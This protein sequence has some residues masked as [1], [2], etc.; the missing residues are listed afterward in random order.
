MVPLPNAWMRLKR[1][2]DVFIAFRGTN[3]VD[4]TEYARLTNALPRTL[5]VGLASSAVNNA[6]GQATTA[7]YREFSDFS[8]SILTQPLSQTVTSDV[9][10]VF[11]VTARGLPA[12][13]YQWYQNGLIL[14]GQTGA[15]L[16]LN[17]VTTNQAGDYFAVVTNLYGAATSHVATLVVDGVG[18]GGFEGDVAPLPNGNNTVSVSDWVRVGR[19]VA[20]LETPLNSGDFARADCAPRTNA[21]TGT[22]PLGNGLLSVADWTQAGRYA[23]G[24]DPLTAAGG[25]A[26]SGGLALTRVLRKQ[27]GEGRA[28]QVMD[29]RTAQGQTVNLTVNLAGLGNENALG[30]SLT[31]NPAALVYRRTSLASGAAGCSVQIN[32]GQAGE[33]RL[34]L[35][36]AKPVGQSFAA[37]VQSLVQIEFSAV[38]APGDTAIAFSDT[39]VFREIADPDAAVLDASFR[40]GTV[41][42]VQPAHLDA[43]LRLSGPGVD[44]RLTGATGET[45]RVEVSSDLLTWEFLANTV[46]GS[47]PVTIID[48]AAAQQSQRFY[49]ASLAP[50]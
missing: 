42:I 10:V 19:L 48:P 23:A 3:G 45:Y 13:E 31:Y 2:D 30:F 14:A 47:Q 16:T 6:A 4:W 28:V 25:P 32:E 36:L 38:G 15:L 21:I 50:Y 26:Q 9:S 39:P 22:L 29:A 41:A 20:G 34:G 12:L 17:N 49:R 27:G 43:V 37:A 46:A 44:L 7:S 18:L 1:E 24:L 40:E 5:L 35:V 11:G 8:P 33:G